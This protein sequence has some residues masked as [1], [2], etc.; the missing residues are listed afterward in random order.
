MLKGKRMILEQGGG[1][2]KTG[3]AV[4]SKLGSR[5][6]AER[7]ALVCAA[8]SRW[9]KLLFCSAGQT[10]GGCRSVILVA[11][12]LPGNE[13]A[14]SRTGA[15]HRL[16]IGL[17]LRARSLFAHG[18][19]AQPNLLL[20]RSHLD[21]LEFVLRSRLQVQ[22]LA[23]SI[24]RLGLVAKPFDAFR[25]LHKRAERRHAQHFAV[26]HIAHMVRLEEGFP[27]VGL[28]LLHA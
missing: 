16:L 21:D 4:S 5:A 2:D 27:N 18:A 10:T 25:N 8:A 19:D 12:A 26:D 11:G 9:A 22:R 7:D 6:D 17:H 23:I 24:H 3:R 28:K 20:F 14:N 13:L 1:W 15:R